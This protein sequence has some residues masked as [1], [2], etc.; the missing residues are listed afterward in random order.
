[1]HAVTRLP[2]PFA[3]TALGTAL[4]CSCSSASTDGSSA[5]AL[6]PPATF[7]A[8]YAAVFPLGTTAQCNYCHDRPANQKS[9]GNLNMG[10]TQDAA[11]AALVGKTS[12]DTLCAGGTQ[13]VVP[14]NPDASLFYAKLTNPPCGERMPQGADPLT[15]A[16]LAMVKSWIAAGAKND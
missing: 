2:L 1:M 8:I 12:Q 5:G 7:T 3:A 4:L 6:S 9:N 13:L 10:H 11:Y 16:Q 14:G 15:D